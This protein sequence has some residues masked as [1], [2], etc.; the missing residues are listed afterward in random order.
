MESLTHPLL[1]GIGNRLRGDDGAGY[2]LAERLLVE[3]EPC[4]TPWQ[5]LAVQQLMPE[6]A[7]AIASADA[8]LFVDAWRLATGPAEPAELLVERIGRHRPPPALSHHCSAG[9][10]LDLSEALYG[11]VPA[12]WQ[13]LL[14][15]LQLGHGMALSPTTACALEAALTLVRQWRP[16]DA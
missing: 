14:P 9:R 2:V 15:A 1:I 7:P 5:V 6:L 16:S 3:P 12:A 13:L 8:V 10:L 4:A 11:H